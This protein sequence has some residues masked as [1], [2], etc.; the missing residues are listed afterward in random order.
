ME[1]DKFSW[2]TVFNEDFAIM[3]GKTWQGWGWSF[4]YYRT[5]PVPSHEQYEPWRLKFSKCQ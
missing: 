3:L 2:I 4:A 1:L 5:A